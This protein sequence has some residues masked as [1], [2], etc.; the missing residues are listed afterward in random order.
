MFDLTGQRF[1]RLVVVVLADVVTRNRR[2]L[3]QCDCGERKTVRGGDLRSGRVH[4]CG[5]LRRQVV[6]AKN[7]THG[8]AGRAAASHLYKVWCA[9]KTRCLN[10]RQA[11][12][13]HYGGRGIGIALEWLNDFSQ[14]ARDVGEPPFPKAM[15][16]RI[17][18]DADYRPGNLRWATRSEQNR[19]RRQKSHC[20]QGHPFDLLNT[21]ID[22]SGRRVCRQCRRARWR[23]WHQSR[24][25]LGNQA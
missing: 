22:P 17:D 6:R 10:P 14:F 7:L 1:G 9:M 11:G 2:W 20:R 18:N 19:N 15:L 16:D 12:F 3:C 23:R 13:K 5:C 21:S 24:R 25:S 4:S 8:Q